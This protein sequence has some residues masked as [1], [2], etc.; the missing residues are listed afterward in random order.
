MDLTI[1]TLL[2]ANPALIDRK[3][4]AMCAAAKAYR[5]GFGVAPVFLRSGG[6]IPVV[7]IFQEA[8]G[9]PT[10]LMGFALPD[11]RLH[12]PN[13]KFHLPNFFRG[14]KTSIRFL[15]EIGDGPS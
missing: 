10:V 9:L 1:R 5:H 15:S 3:H 2:S 13:E 6:S 7:N 11:D 14:I 4:P 8:L 12:E